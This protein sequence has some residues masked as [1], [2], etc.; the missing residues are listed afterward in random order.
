LVVRENS[1]GE[2]MVK[3]L[4]KANK[5]TR[6]LALANYIENGYFNM[7]GDED[8]IVGSGL[9]MAEI[10]VTKP[11]FINAHDPHHPQV[12][13][14]LKPFSSFYG[15]SLEET[16]DIYLGEVEGLDGLE[17]SAKQAATFLRQ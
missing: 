2:N 13:A 17:T 7:Y 16:K 5:R 8:C 3:N 4:R 12:E 11:A 10:K 15:Y 1:L 9:K 14:I 6:R